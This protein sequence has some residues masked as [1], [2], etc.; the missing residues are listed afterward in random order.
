[1]PPATPNTSIENL[2]GST[3][4]DTLFGNAEANRIDGNLGSDTL[5]ASP[6]ASSLAGRSGDDVISAERGRRT[7]RQRRQ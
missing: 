4:N 6:V 1:M 3:L 5:R 7:G 2:R